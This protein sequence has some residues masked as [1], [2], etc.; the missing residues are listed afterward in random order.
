MNKRDVELYLQSFVI[1]EQE[2]S[3]WAWAISETGDPCRLTKE[4]TNRRYKTQV[5][6]LHAGIS[7]C[8]TCKP[9][10]VGIARHEARMAEQYQHQRRQGA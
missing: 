4:F 6:A 1:T 5:D 2:G 7:Y 10:L 8:W 9:N 3:G